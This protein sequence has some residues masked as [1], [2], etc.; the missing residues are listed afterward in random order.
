MR[1]AEEA[2]KFRKKQKMKSKIALLAVLIALLGGATSAT[3][4]AQSTNAPAHQHR[5][6]HPKIH[7]AIVALEE[8]K[9]E[10]K[11]AA[12]DFGGHREAALKECDAAIV[13]LRLALQY[14]KK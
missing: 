7:H 11:S 12:H 9:L 6:R 2:P 13:E 14:D 10:L 3:V 5:E 1:G 8:A 4:L